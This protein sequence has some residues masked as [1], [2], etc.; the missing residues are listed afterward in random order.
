VSVEFETRTKHGI[1]GSSS[2]LCLSTHDRRPSTSCDDGA[3][4]LA[5]GVPAS[6]RTVRLR[7]SNGHTIDSRVIPVPAR[8]GGPGGVYAFVVQSSMAFPVRLTE[9]D[10]HGKA[11][12]TIELAKSRRCR[13]E[14]SAAFPKFISLVHGTTPAGEPFTIQGAQFDFGGH[15]GFSLE[16]QATGRDDTEETFTGQQR[17]F[18]FTLQSECAPHAYTIIYGTLAPPG[19]SVLAE[20]SEGPVALTKVELDPSYHAKGPLFYGVYR[21]APSALIVRR[22]DGSTLYTESLVA[23]AKEEAEFCEGYVEG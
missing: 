13:H 23:N 7:L 10:A 18:E 14:R 22:A 19:D 8:D 20:T 3:E 5:L 21:T 16:L 15:P 4:E 12:R 1:E 11:L 6:V 17:A 9:L 2:S